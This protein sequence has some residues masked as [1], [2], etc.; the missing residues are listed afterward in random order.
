[1]TRPARVR[2]T[3][4]APLTEWFATRGWKPAPFQ[5]EVWKRWLAGESGLLHTP[6]AASPL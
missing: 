1:M 3:F 5:R 6:I 2:R 4:D